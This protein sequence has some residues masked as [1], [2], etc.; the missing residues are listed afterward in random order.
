MGDTEGRLGRHFNLCA[1]Y[2]SLHP[3]AILAIMYIIV[4]IL[5]PNRVIAKSPSD[6]SDSEVKE[7]DVETET[8]GKRGRESEESNSWINLIERRERKGDRN[9]NSK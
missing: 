2:S 3:I 8:R 1:V 6:L 4:L 7:L 5:N 9:T